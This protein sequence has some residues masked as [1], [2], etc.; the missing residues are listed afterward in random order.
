[1][2]RK[3]TTWSSS[4]VAL[5]IS[6]ICA[7]LFLSFFCCNTTLLNCFRSSEC[8]G[9]HCDLMYYTKHFLH[10][11]LSVSTRRIMYEPLISKPSIQRGLTKRN[12]GDDTERI[13]QVDY[14][15]INCGGARWNIMIITFPFMA[16][17][18]CNA[19]KIGSSNE[20]LKALHSSYFWIR[21]AH[22]Y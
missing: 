6:V 16:Q 20:G 11:F 2:W 10:S 22:E 7:C 13:S 9:Y 3:Q 1:M 17:Y 21:D 14:D 19:I 4:F 8:L 15:M 18:G 12:S 5:H